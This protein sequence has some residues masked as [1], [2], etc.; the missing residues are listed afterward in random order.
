M[1]KMLGICRNW[2]KNAKNPMIDAQV[3]RRNDFAAHGSHVCALF[4]DFF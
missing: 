3:P 4:F 1:T 2:I